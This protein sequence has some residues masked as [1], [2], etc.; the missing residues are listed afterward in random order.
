MSDGKWCRFGH[1]VGVVFVFSTM[2]S[3]NPS[4]LEENL[5]AW[6]FLSSQVVLSEPDKLTV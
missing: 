1:L 2:W 6:F 4:R 5:P 3:K